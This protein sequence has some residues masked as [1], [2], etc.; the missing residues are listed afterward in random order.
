MTSPLT[1]DTKGKTPDITL[2]DIANPTCASSSTLYM[3]D[4]YELSSFSQAEI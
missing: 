2:T 4:D 1:P 3:T